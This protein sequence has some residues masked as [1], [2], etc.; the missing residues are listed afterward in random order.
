M[1]FGYILREEPTGF[2]KDWLRGVREKQNKTGD[3]DDVERFSLNYRKDGIAVK[4]GRRLESF[5]YK[6]K[7]PV[8]PPVGDTEYTVGGMCLEV[9]GAV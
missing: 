3:E 5:G 7:T 1:D 4:W 8:R 6:F 9:R 2:I